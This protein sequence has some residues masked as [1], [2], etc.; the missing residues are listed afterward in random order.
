MPAPVP[1]DPLRYLPVPPPPPPP[2]PSP[3]TMVSSG[4]SSMKQRFSV[5]PMW[6]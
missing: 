5:S 6:K 3:M 2:P 4:I 1:V